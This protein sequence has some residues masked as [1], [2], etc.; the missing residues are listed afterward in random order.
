MSD[1][2]TFSYSLQPP[3]GIQTHEPAA[4]SAEIPYDA[5]DPSAIRVTQNRLNEILTS[6]KDAIGDLEKSKE[7]PGV[8]GYG[9]G[10]A[11]KMQEKEDSEEE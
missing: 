8:I 9:Q 1:N 2:I 4:A 7:D 11:S 5:Y 10:K 6:W 3:K